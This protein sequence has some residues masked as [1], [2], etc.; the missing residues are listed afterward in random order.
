MKKILNFPIY[1]ICSVKGNV[2]KFLISVGLVGTAFAAGTTIVDCPIN[3]VCI[4]KYDYVSNK[5]EGNN[6]TPTVEASVASQIF[7]DP[8]FTGNV[9]INIY[10]TPLGRGFQVIT[11]TAAPQ[12]TLSDVATSTP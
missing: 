1:L 4:E 9:I 6:I 10:K 12:A 2:K 11:K 3:V 5:T 7:S 8:N